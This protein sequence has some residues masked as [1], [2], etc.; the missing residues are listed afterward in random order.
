MLGKSLIHAEALPQFA[1]RSVLIVP[2]VDADGGGLEAAT[3]R[4]TQLTS[5]GCR[6]W[7]IDLSD[8]SIRENT[9]VKAPATGAASLG[10]EQLGDRHPE[11]RALRNT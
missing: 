2:D 9:S 3:R 11:R 4:D 8:L 5:V 10:A 7:M 1:N 6:V